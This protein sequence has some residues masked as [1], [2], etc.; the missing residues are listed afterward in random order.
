MEAL[1]TSLNGAKPNATAAA[2]NRE[3][4]ETVTELRFALLRAST[5]L[6]C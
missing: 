1:R 2:P 5:R 3:C 6:L 4:E